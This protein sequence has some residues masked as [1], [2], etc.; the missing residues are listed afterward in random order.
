[1]PKFYPKPAHFEKKSQIV[2]NSLIF[3]KFLSDSSIRLMCALNACPENWT[4]IQCDIQK[5]LGWGKEKMRSAIKECIKYGYLKVTQSRRAHTEREENGSFK[6]GQFSYHEFEFDIEGGYSKN[7]SQILYEE[8]PDIEYE[9]DGGNPPPARLDPVTSPLLS[10][11]RIDPYREK[12]ETPD[13][14][15][16]LNE[17]DQKKIEFLAPFDLDESHLSVL[18]A[19]DLNRIV[20][21]VNAALQWKKTKEDKGQT[22][23]ELGDA[24]VRFVTQGWKP[25]KTQEDIEAEKKQ[26]AAEKESKMLERR[27]EAREIENVWAEKLPFKYSFKVCER[28]ISIKVKDSGYPID[29]SDENSLQRLMEHIEKYKDSNENS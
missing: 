8:C 15:S 25:N 20:L 7:D 16:S 22:I 6:K 4:I 14:L 19:Y 29:L 1:M 11:H 2:P 17:E 12:K 28:T 26:I 23:D 21:G 13:F 5:R 24:F 3:H 10:S 27:K 18:L 9:P